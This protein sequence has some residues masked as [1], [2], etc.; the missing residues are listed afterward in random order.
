MWIKRRSVRKLDD[1]LVK[2]YARQSIIV[3]YEVLHFEDKN[4]SMIFTEIG[5]SF[6]NNF[7]TIIKLYFLL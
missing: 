6:V 1:E 5:Y 4:Y 7:K 3:F 2:V